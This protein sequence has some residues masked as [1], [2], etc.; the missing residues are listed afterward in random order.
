MGEMR[1]LTAGKNH[2][3]DLSVDGRILQDWKYVLFG[4]H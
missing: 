2:F 3:E 1:N 4:V